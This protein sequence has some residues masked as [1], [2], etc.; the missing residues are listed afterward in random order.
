MQIRKTQ[1]E[2][3]KRLCAIYASARQFMKEQGNPHQ[4]GDDYPCEDLLREDIAAGNSYVGVVADR[5]VAAF[6]F[7]SMEIDPTYGHI[8]NG[9][10]KNTLSYGV[11]HRLASDGTSQGVAQNC[12]DWCKKQ[13]DNLKI[14]THRDN[15]VMQKILAA[16]GF[17][18]CGLI[19]LPDGSERLAYQYTAE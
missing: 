6:Y 18:Y 5:I 14:D 8:R 3:L 9:S 17:Q 13:A 2:D 1:L 4:W 10:W 16:N 15:L 11:I 12:L 7:A 19:D